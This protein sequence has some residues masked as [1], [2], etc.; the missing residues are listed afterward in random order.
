[1]EHCLS[2][3][4]NSN[5]APREEEIDQILNI[6]SESAHDL[7]LLNEQILRLQA[8]LQ[9]ITARRDDIQAKLD[10]YRVVISPLRRCPTEILQQIFLWTIDPFPVLSSC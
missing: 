4:L 9:L 5:C 7:K 6:F 1:M 10:A 3:L 8:S 2:N